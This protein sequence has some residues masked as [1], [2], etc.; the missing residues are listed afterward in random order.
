MISESPL[1]VRNESLFNSDIVIK[2]IMNNKVVLFQVSCTCNLIL[3]LTFWSL[4]Y[5]SCF[6]DS[7]S[8]KLFLL[9]DNKQITFELDKRS[10]LYW[11]R[12]LLL[13]YFVQLGNETDFSIEWID[14][15]KVGTCKM[16]NEIE[17]KRNKSKRNLPKR[18]ET[19]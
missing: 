18:K 4:I 16:R 17:T 1:T 7:S 9:R 19:K 13:R 6:L 14:S 12:A 8:Q 3:F 5:Y 10:V 2:L 15:D 11:R